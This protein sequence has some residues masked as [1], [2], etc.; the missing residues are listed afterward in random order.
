MSTT[1]IFGQDNDRGGEQCVVV[2]FDLYA[3][4]H[5]AA[6]E[7]LAAALEASGIRSHDGVEAWSFPE[8]QDK[9]IDGSDPLD[10]MTLTP[11]IVPGV[12]TCGSPGA[13][14]LHRSTCDGSDPLARLIDPRRDAYL[15]C[16]AVSG[17]GRRDVTGP[18]RAAGF[19]R[20][21]VVTDAAWER[22]VAWWDTS[23]DPALVEH[24]R[25][26]DVLATARL[27]ALRNAGRPEPANFTIR[28]HSNRP[29]GGPRETVALAVHIGP[30][31]G[32][33]PVLVTIM[34][35]DEA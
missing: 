34:L 8:P 31:A 10:P 2:V 7:H 33:L 11:A 17:P 19:T 35:H 18:A 4:T 22:T 21:A 12:C 13:S 1:R 28:S 26:A 20:P 3:D 9:H 30:G 25:L 32:D 15:P 14:G 5:H 27:A 29:H 23:D 16:Y 24:D 6:A